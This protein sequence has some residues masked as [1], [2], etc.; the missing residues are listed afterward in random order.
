VILIKRRLSYRCLDTQVHLVP[1]QVMDGQLM[2]STGT[3]AYCG[4]RITASV[5]GDIDV[6]T[7]ATQG[8][9]VGNRRED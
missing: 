1:L 6:G 7:A 9:C 4:Q 3:C 8:A 2:R 5:S